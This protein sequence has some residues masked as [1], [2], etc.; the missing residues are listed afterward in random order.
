M[1]QLFK[2]TVFLLHVVAAHAVNHAADRIFVGHVV[3]VVVGHV[4][5]SLV[6]YFLVAASLWWESVIHCLSYHPQN[7]QFLPLP[8]CFN[9]RIFPQLFLQH[10]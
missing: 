7:Q 8:Q 9:F 5:V 2:M 6:V 4:V 1:T 10:P 3:V